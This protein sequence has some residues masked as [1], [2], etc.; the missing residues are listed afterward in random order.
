MKLSSFK[1]NTRFNVIFELLNNCFTIKHSIQV[2]SSPC[3]SPTCSN[4]IDSCWFH[5]NIFDVDGLARKKWWYRK[6]L[7]LNLGTI[8]LKYSVLKHATCVRDREVDYSSCFRDVSDSLYP[9]KL[10]LQGI[11][12]GGPRGVPLDPLVV[13]DYSNNAY[14]ERF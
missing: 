4:P 9:M 12:G 1:D 11:R 7:S 5:Q 3:W 10:L 13:K 14:L 8:C 6:L 2:K